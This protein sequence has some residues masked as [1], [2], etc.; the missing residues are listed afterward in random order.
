[1]DYKKGKICEKSVIDMLNH[2][3]N[4]EFKDYRDDVILPFEKFEPSRHKYSWFDFYN[5]YVV[6]ELKSQKDD[7]RTHHDAILP[8][9]KTLH[10]NSLFFFLFNNQQIDLNKNLYFM[11]YDDKLF[12]N[13]RQ[14][15]I[16]RKDRVF[17]KSVLCYMIPKFTDY[18]KLSFQDYFIKYEST[19]EYEIY[20]DNKK[21]NQI[22]IQT[23]INYDNKKFVEQGF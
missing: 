4:F 17:A 5:D 3:K 21:D 1:M 22:L 7:V 19:E 16:E 10:E 18:D 13:F 11:L 6:C 8:V 15:E 14:Q 23:I 12:N 20:I 2:A 9:S